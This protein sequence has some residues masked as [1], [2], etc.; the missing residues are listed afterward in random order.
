M[1]K[2]YTRGCS[3]GFSLI[4]LLLAMGITSVVLGAILAIT[5]SSREILET[6][7]NRT[8]LNQ[9][10]RGGMDLMGVDIRQ[11]GERLPGDVPALELLNGASGAPDSIVIRRNMID[12]VL[13]VCKE[14]K[15]GSNADSIF[16]AWKNGKI[17]GC[18]PVLDNNG[19]GWPDDLEAWR[20]Y[21]LANGGS[22][23][24]Y[25]YNPTSSEGEFFVYDAEDKSTFH[26]HK[27]N[28]DPWNVDYHV[29]E[30]PRVYILEQREFR[31]ANNRLQCVING[32]TSQPLNLASDITDLQGRGFYLDGTILDAIGPG[33]PWADLQSVEV[34][35]SG[36][37][38]F[39]QRSMQRSVISRFFPRNVLTIAEP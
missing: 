12:V 25:I 39:N 17:E 10:L 23:L 2:P 11:A 20:E 35:L 8:S 27:A 33:N 30:Q 26:I 4:E 1:S 16:V 15:A 9:N 13:P 22:V 31:V 34:R 5:L 14:I 28:G 6:D 37:R 3:R 32:D 29:D 38:D 21:R 18:E 36:Q 24:A 19:D 7:Q